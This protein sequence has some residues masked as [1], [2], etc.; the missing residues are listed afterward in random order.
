MPRRGLVYF[1]QFLLICRRLKITGLH[2][3]K[4]LMS[5]IMAQKIHV[6]DKI[7]LADYCFGRR[8]LDSQKNSLPAAT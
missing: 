7:S 8:R 5:R 1:E 4:K 2:Y 6:C 3:K